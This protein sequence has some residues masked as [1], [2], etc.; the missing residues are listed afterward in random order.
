MRQHK[1]ILEMD[2]GAPPPRG[3]VIE[4]KRKPGCFVPAFRNQALEARAVAEAVAEQV[5]LCGFDR[6]RFTLVGRQGAD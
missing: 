6:F 4:I 3:V 2:A 1:K 5:S